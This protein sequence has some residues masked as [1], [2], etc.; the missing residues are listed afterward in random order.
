MGPLA[1]PGLT[2]FPSDSVWAVSN[3]AATKYTPENDIQPLSTGW[4]PFRPSQPMYSTRPSGNT[5]RRTSCRRWGQSGC[6][7]K[8]TSLINRAHLVVLSDDSKHCP[9]SGPMPLIQHAHIVTFVPHIPAV[10]FHQTHQ[11]H[12]PRGEEES[13]RGHMRIHSNVL[14]EAVTGGI[15][16]SDWPKIRPKSSAARH[17]RRRKAVAN[18]TH[19]AH[20][21]RVTARGLSWQKH[22][23]TA[24][25]LIAYVE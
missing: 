16:V 14:L 9:H 11:H 7:H 19:R 3:C 5:S 4:P 20:C 12:Q 23:H 18:T 1:P 24:W 15:A 13:A 22:I 10:L 17:S 21:A 25:R 2:V 8:H 6:A